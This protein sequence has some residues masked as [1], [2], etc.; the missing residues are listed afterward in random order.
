M[1]EPRPPSCTDWHQ[2]SAAVIWLASYS[3][4]KLIASSCRK[5]SKAYEALISIGLAVDGDCVG[6]IGGTD[7]GEGGDQTEADQHVRQR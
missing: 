5:R 1:A 6:S 2:S 4:T 3:V 7:D